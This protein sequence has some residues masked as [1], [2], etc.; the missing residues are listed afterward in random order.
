LLPQMGRGT[1]SYTV[2]CIDSN[3]LG[4]FRKECKTA[5]KQI[6]VWTVNQADHMIEVNLYS[7]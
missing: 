5:G 2:T 6:M 7:V 1:F 3:R 4:R